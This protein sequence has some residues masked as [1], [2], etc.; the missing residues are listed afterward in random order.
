MRKLTKKFL[1]KTAP[2]IACAFFCGATPLLAQGILSV[3]PG[4][5]IATNTG[6]RVVGYGG[7]GGTATSATLASPSATAYDTNGNLFIADTQNHV[8]RKVSADGTITTVAGNG[9][10]GFGGDGAAA[11]QAYLDTPTGVA[12]DSSGDI[13]IADSHNNRIRKVANGV[14]ST[15]AGTATAG[16]SG[17]GGAAT[18]AQLSLP[19]SVAADSA[20]NLYI[21][22]TNNQ[23]IRKVAGNVITTVAGN[24]NEGFAGDGGAAVA[25]SLDLPTGVAVDSSGKIYIADQH[26]HRVRVVDPAGK[27]STIAGSG[28]TVT[29]AGG[30]SGDGANAAAALL[31]KPSGVSVDNAGNVYIAD[32]NNQRIRQVGNGTIV[33]LAGTGQQG[34]AGDSGIA[35][36]A[37]LNAPRG[38]TADA[39]G[40]LA[41]ADT[42]NERIRNSKLPLLAFAHQPVG[43]PSTPQTVTLTNIGNAP[44]TVSQ[45]N[46]IGA[47]TTASGGTCSTAP[48][49]LAPGANCTQ[50]IA[51]LPLASGATDGSVSF[52]GADI[53]PQRILLNGSAEQ[54]ST[55][56]SLVTNASPSLL[57][58][59]IMFTATVA[60]AGSA[61]GVITFHDGP[62]VLGAP[63]LI[64]GSASVTTSTLSAGSHTITAVYGGDPNFIGSSS[65]ILSQVVQDFSFNPVS[66]AD[67]DQTVQPGQA[68]TYKFSLQPVSSAFTFPITL[69]ATGLPPGATVAFSPQTFTPG[70]TGTNFSMVVTTPG[71]TA[72]LHRTLSGSGILIAI[73]FIPFFDVSRK[74]SQKIKP[75]LL[76][77]IA[78]VGLAA[79]TGLTGCGAGNGFFSETP[80]NYTITVTG[81]AAGP[82]NT[83]L[84]HTTS[85]RLTVQ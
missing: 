11:T 7:D 44:I 12:V 36:S 18:S 74:R 21:A 43:T 69:S 1:Q 85:V 2:S 56:T 60:A 71:I 27:I 61:T 46:F 29:F 47:F 77:A 26:N 9:T 33:T 72:S 84:Q 23:R 37:L 49:I 31:A 73:F 50:N 20:G 80:K 28:T 79:I 62:A 32:T 63:S 57:G 68:A 64:S 48:I 4:R 35:T 52:G 34:F 10:A 40:N 25:A 38:V 30:Y 70:P 15:I 81:T 8:V 59:P 66:G 22:D 54:S 6:T 51:Y 19:S 42:L 3:T 55:T 24:G 65:P 76:S 13:Y 5:S 53:A 78:L 16:F 17:D 41:I 82:Q 39:S 83:T 14:I 67:T 45:I 75:L 58:Q